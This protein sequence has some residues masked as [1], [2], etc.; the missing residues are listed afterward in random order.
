M[1]ILI[2]LMCVGGYWG[3]IYLLVW[4]CTDT[5]WWMYMCAEARSWHWT[6]FLCGPPPSFFD[7]DVSLILKFIVGLGWLAT[8]LQGSPVSTFPSSKC[9]G[10]K[11]FVWVLWILLFLCLH[12]IHSLV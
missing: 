4:L 6:S 7:I 10:N 9:W 3:Y 1:L 8:K 5:C 12:D 11:L 2:F